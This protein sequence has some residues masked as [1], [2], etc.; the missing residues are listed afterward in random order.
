MPS[1]SELS[2]ALGISLSTLREQLE[3]AR[4]LGFI[5]IKPRAGMRT[6]PYNFSNTVKLSTCYGIKE[7]PL[8]SNNIHHF[9]ITLSY[10]TGMKPLD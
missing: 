7:P 1:L 3:V 6:L 5:E 4:V 9:E 2:K 10:L 8:Y